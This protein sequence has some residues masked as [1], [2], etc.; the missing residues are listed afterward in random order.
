[1]S[2]VFFNHGDTPDAAPCRRVLATIRAVTTCTTSVPAEIQKHTIC[3][4]PVLPPTSRILHACRPGGSSGLFR[5]VARR[6]PEVPAIFIPLRFRHWCRVTQCWFCLATLCVINKITMTLRSIQN[7]ERTLRYRRYLRV[8]E[9]L[10]TEG[11]WWLQT[12]LWNIWKIL[13][14]GSRSE[15]LQ[16]TPA[17]PHGLVPPNAVNAAFLYIVSSPYIYLHFFFYQCIIMLMR[18]QRLNGKY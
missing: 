10:R 14:V 15:G 4:P 9:F 2:L 17:G 18:V 16:V 8:R 11:H 6:F 3:F 1:M 12:L 13:E 7:K 5:G